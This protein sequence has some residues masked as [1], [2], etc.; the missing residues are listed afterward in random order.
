[1]TSMRFDDVTVGELLS[2]LNVYEIPA[3]QRDY[4]WT[5]AEAQGLLEDL[6]T[7][8]DTYAD[9]G[10]ALPY[11]LGSM[12]FVASDEPEASV[13]SALVV[14]GQQR[15]VT[16]TILLAVLRD[17]AAAEERDRLHANIALLTHA[18]PFE[19][20]LFHV[21]PRTGDAR[22]LERRIQRRGATLLPTGKSDLKPY[23]EPQRRMEAVRVYLV[24]RLKR[25]RR[26][27]SA[28]RLAALAGFVL[29]NCRTLRLW[30]PDIDYAYRVFLSINKPGLPLTEEDIVLAEVVGPL[31]L[32]QRRRF[33]AII[34]EMARYREPRQQNSRQDKT[35]FTHLAA[36]Q[37]WTRKDRMIT[38]LRRQVS[39][40]GGPMRFAADVFEPMAI[41]YLITRGNWVREALSERAWNK[42]DGLRLLERFCDN[43]W[44]APAM[45]ALHHYR[46]DDNAI[47]D[48]L[49]ALDRFA[50]TVALVRT[51]PEDRR[52]IYRPIIE[53]ISASRRPLDPAKLFAIEGPREAAAVRKAAL[54]L[55]VTT[56]GIDKAVLIRL[57]AHLSKRP[58][59]AYLE[60]L[61]TK[62][63]A[64]D[65]LT[66]E[67]VLPEGPTLSRSSAWWPEFHNSDYRRGVA[68]AIANLVLLEEHRNKAAGQSDFAA[69]K[70]VFFPDD[71][72]HTLYLTDQ[73]RHSSHWDRAA[74]TARQDLLMKAFC[75]LFGFSVP[76]PPLPEPVANSSSPGDAP[77]VAEKTGRSS[78][79]GKTARRKR[80]R[81]KTVG[82]KAN[83][84]TSAGD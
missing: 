30:A 52:Q 42:L 31:A 49:D 72:P 83:P 77:P 68:N 41:S 20:E 40:A 65:R 10:S 8:L 67:H 48:F 53:K 36:A 12:L 24:R 33:D 80:Q 60:T 51:G 22:F 69:K 13:R 79:T 64:G 39:K 54:K 26:D 35:F 58:L 66:L 76:P 37:M 3:F 9:D 47:C 62:F 84:K 2:G 25:L 57:D 70:R 23:N 75:E 5:E 27:G 29:N 73:V 45:H 46:D 59:S 17:L 78:P 6:L 44:V 28:D 11:F 82:V 63:V 34:S 19:L 74:L 71:E 4:A 21:R 15:L 81:S 14:D 43:E 55:N 16:L 38:L 50:Y 32:A 7:A 61:D 18:E 1:M 56:N